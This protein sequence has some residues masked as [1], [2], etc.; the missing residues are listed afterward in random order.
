MRK[1]LLPGILAVFFLFLPLE[2]QAVPLD[3]PY[4]ILV[5]TTVFNASSLVISTNNFPSLVPSVNANV[6]IYQW[7]ID[8]AVVSTPSAGLFTMFWSTSPLTVGTTDYAAATVA[9]TAYDTNLNYRMPYCAPVGDPILTLKSSVSGS[10]I[11]A[12]GFLY[13]GWT[14]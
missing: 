4:Q 1:L 11:T 7:C 13:K 6:G 10:T 14:P 12:S 2:S 5:T 8:H 9:N 3:V